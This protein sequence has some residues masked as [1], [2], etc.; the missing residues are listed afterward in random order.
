V[1]QIKPNSDSVCDSF[2]AH[3]NNNNISY[4][5]EDLT[6]E[7]M[8]HA[9]LIDGMS[10]NES[11]SLFQDSDS[12]CSF[13]SISKQNNDLEASYVTSMSKNPIT[14]RKTESLKLDSVQSLR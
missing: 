12:I 4:N 2:S 9:N 10:P 1:N 6:L 8:V 11:V 7:A 5:T 13:R 14:L 3:F